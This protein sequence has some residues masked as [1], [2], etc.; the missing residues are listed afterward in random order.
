MR[1]EVKLTAEIGGKRY[2][3]VPSETCSGCAFEPE[4]GGNHELDTPMVKGADGLISPCVEFGIIYEELPP[5]KVFVVFR[6]HGGLEAI[7]YDTV[8]GIFS[9][10]E[11][12]KT[13][14]GNEYKLVRPDDKWVFSE[15]K[16]EDNDFI[17]AEVVQTDDEFD[18]FK[19]TEMEVQ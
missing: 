16:P 8:C 3:C 17:S 6:V 11:D 15:E 2:A 5:Q 7:D 10:I 9:N 13:C 4:C 14:L 12:A 19:V 1:R 18:R